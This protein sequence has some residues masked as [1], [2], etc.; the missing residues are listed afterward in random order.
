MQRPIKAVILGTTCSGKTSVGNI[1][2]EK[3]NFPVVD[4]DDEA[5]KIKRDIFINRDE[6]YIDKVFESINQ[7]VIKIE[8]VLFTTSFL[9][10]E[11]IVEFHDSDFKIIHLYTTL[12]ELIKRRT[13]RHGGYLS[14]ERLK[15]AKNNHKQHMEIEKDKKLSKLIDLSLDTTNMTVEEVTAGIVRFLSNIQ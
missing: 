9:E 2:S 15:R 12:E 7:R 14:K 3:Y 10:P 11:R 8:S 5:Y 4:V 1:L 6:E 13:K